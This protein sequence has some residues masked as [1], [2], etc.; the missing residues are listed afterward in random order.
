MQANE[1]WEKICELVE[2]CVIPPNFSK[3][4]DETN[5]LV[6]ALAN[7]SGVDIWATS[8]QANSASSSPIPL[9]WGPLPLDGVFFTENARDKIYQNNVPSNIPY[10][11][12]TNSYEGTLLFPE[13]R[14]AGLTTEAF[15]EILAFFMSEL[16]TTEDVLRKWDIWLEAYNKAS[17]ITTKQS[18]EIVDNFLKK[19]RFPK[20]YV[21]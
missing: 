10:Y 11:I 17:G 16:T 8:I 6:T 3:S 15:A 18:A 7:L 12:T 4:V 1:I 9:S 14:T 21:F 5:E 13:L 19:K 20:F 2:S